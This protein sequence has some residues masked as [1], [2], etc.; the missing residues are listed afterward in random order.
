[1]EMSLILNLERV[2]Q[3]K[4]RIRAWKIDKKNKV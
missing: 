1:M 3:Y 4:F 2:P